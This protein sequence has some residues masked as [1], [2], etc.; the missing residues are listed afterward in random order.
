MRAA[1]RRRRHGDDD[2]TAS[3]GIGAAV[4]HVRW[5]A[6]AAMTRALGGVHRAAL[7]D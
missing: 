1:A 7:L 4:G 2:G 6:A 3:R 5:L